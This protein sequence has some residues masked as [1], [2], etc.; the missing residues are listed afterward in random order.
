[1]CA[2]CEMQQNLRDA[3]SESRSSGRYNLPLALALGV[4]DQSAFGLA[5]WREGRGE[6]GERAVQ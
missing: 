3:T 5:L 1:M 6:Q 4:S 2:P